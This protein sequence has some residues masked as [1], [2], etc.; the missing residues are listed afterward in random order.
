MRWALFVAMLGPE[1]YGNVFAAQIKFGSLVALSGDL[2]AY[3]PAIDNGAQMAKD[4]LNRAGGILGR[5]VVLV[6]RDT[7][8]NPPGIEIDARNLK[9][10]LKLVASG[11]DV[12]YQGVSGPCNF[13][14]HGDVPGSFEVWRF[15]GGSIET[16]TFITVDR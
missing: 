1:A 6:T 2:G 15:S 12:D 13:D 5:E 10:A 11:I 8:T 4:D 14:G 3:G 9:R 16:V 7:R